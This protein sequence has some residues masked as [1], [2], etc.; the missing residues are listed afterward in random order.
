MR[1][2]GIDPGSIV[3]GYG[4]VE[5]VQERYIDVTHGEIKLKRGL[6]FTASL[7]KVY[8]ELFSII[9]GERPDAVAIEDI[10]YG[11]NIKS[12]IKQGHVRGVAILAGSKHHL[13]VFEYTP[14]EVKKAVVGYGRAEKIQV[15]KMIQVM[16]KFSELPPEDASDAIAVAICHINH[17]KKVSI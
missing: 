16:M 5:K 11:K 6:L 15:Q 2:L 12:L 8:N 10:F 1:V 4:I 17:Q 3:T 7:E 9:E 13:P 14:L